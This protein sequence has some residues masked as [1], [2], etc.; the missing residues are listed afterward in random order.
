MA[1]D[2][3]T[4]LYIAYTL[5]WLGLLAYLIYIHT[6]QERLRREMTIFQR[7]MRA[8]ERRK[9]GETEREE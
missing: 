8:R 2:G 4:G 1:D 7:R 5:V 9:D 6:L 3:L